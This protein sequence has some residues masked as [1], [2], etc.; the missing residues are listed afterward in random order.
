M[1][2]INNIDKNSLLHFFTPYKCTAT[3]LSGNFHISSRLTFDEL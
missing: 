2:Q 1:D 3:T